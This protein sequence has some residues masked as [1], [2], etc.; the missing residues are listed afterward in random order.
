MQ[1]AEN[2]RQSPAGLQ[3]RIRDFFTAY[4]QR[5]A[6]G[7]EGKT[8]V[9]G[10]AAVFTDQF[11]EANPFGVSAGAN[12]EQF[13]KAI[14]EGMEFY[15]KIGTR[16]MELDTVAITPLD[17]NHHMAKVHWKATYVKEGKDELVIEFD[18]IYLLQD[19]D[20]ALKIFAY[21]TGDEQG[22]LKEHGLI[23]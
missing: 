17:A 15:R 9:E 1:D 4:E 21:I 10:T 22:V 5:Y 23:N 13:R 16:S 6:A 3:S 20:G 2:T 8:D 14:P 11:I 19:I 7:L 18:V 12:D